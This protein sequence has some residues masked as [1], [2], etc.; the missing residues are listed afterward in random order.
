M[1]YQR[2]SSYKR[3]TLHLP[4]IKP[5]SDGIQNLVEKSVSWAPK[6]ERNTKIDG[7]DSCLRS[8]KKACDHISSPYNAFI[9]KQVAFLKVK[10]L[11]RRVLVFAKKGYF[12][13]LWKPLEEN[14]ILSAI[15]SG[16]ESNE[17]GKLEQ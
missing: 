2:Q 8:W 3:E 13:L 4:T 12:K 7:R 15:T 16:K 17:P 6:A 9:H 11:A 5:G 1:L 10:M 14:M